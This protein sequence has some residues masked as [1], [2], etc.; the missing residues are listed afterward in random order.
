MAWS[1]KIECY[2]ELLIYRDVS[3]NTSKFFGKSLVGV[4]AP[5][6]ACSLRPDEIPTATFR[7]LYP[8]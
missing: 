2:I 6:S 1:L 3:H 5:K 8:I 7:D 4:V